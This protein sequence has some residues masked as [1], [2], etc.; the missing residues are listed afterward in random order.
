MG[1]AW[2]SFRSQQGKRGTSRQSSLNSTS[3][4]SRSGSPHPHSLEVLSLREECGPKGMQAS[5]RVQSQTDLSTSAE[6]TRTPS[7]EDSAPVL[8][9]DSER[10]PSKDPP[11]VDAV[12]ADE[13]AMPEAWRS[14]G[15]A[16]IAAE[17]LSECRPA[18]VVGE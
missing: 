14:Q 3:R 13:S 17:G 2:H 18:F 1:T 5:S 4:K 9:E 8:A 10:S 15:A 11:A 7:S 6:P 12:V 16:A